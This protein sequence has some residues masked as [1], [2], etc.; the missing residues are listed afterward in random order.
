M[1]PPFFPLPFPPFSNMLTYSGGW[2]TYSSLRPFHTKT[3]TL[4]CSGNTTRPSP[5]LTSNK[6]SVTQVISIPYPQLVVNPL[7]YSTDYSQVLSCCCPCALCHPAP[8]TGVLTSSCYQS[9]CCWSPL[10]GG[11]AHLS[12]PL[13]G[14]LLH[15]AISSVLARDP[16]T[17]PVDG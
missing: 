9:D 8:H 12:T 16:S 14:A 10:T 15:S 4:G 17:R 13:W 5:L 1:Q 6:S 11:T 7:P 2:L 3:A